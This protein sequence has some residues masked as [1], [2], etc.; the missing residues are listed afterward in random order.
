MHANAGAVT[1]LQQAVAHLSSAPLGKKENTH[2]H[3]HLK[4]L[5]RSYAGA[6]MPKSRKTIFRILGA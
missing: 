2:T 4:M 6:R 3:T 5:M 1:A